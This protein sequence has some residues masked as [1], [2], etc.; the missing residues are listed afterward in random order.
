MKT[1]DRIF[2]LVLAA[3]VL[4]MFAVIAG[5]GAERFQ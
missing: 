2:L 3:A 1:G 4:L 5:I